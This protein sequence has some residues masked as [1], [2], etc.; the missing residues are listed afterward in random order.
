MFAVKLLPIFWLK[1]PLTWQ[2][3]NKTKSWN[4]LLSISCVKLKFWILVIEIFISVQFKKRNDP[5]WIIFFFLN[6]GFICPIFYMAEL[7]I[8]HETFPWFLKDCAVKEIFWNND[9][10]NMIRIKRNWQI[11]QLDIV[12]DLSETVLKL[13]YLTVFYM[14][15]ISAYS[16]RWTTICIIIYN[17]I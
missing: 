1:I 15:N 7:Q 14:S 13:D 12:S 8:I 10:Y 4:K 17:K 6:N 9:M 2:K 11:L 16:E 5:L 3:L